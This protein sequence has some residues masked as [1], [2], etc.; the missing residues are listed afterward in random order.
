MTSKNDVRLSDFILDQMEPILQEWE[1]FAKT[2]EPPA[3]TMDSKALRNHASLMLK[4][5]ALDLGNVQ[6]ALERAEKSKGWGPQRDEETAAETHAVARLESGYTINQ[7]VSEFRAL[8]ASV[9]PLG[10]SFK[11]RSGD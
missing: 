8:R 2:I 9:L 7:L 5:I 11:G 4:A 3:F 1:N 10:L 6:T